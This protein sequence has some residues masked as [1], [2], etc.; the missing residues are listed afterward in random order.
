MIPLKILKMKYKKEKKIGLLTW[1]SQLNI[2]IYSYV[3]LTSRPCTWISCG[4]RF[5]SSL[6]ANP[7]LSHCTIF[8]IINKNNSGPYINRPNKYLYTRKLQLSITYN[9]DICYRETCKRIGSEGVITKAIL[10]VC[11]LTILL[12][13]YDML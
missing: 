11:W 9:N 5:F 1:R 10:Q 12:C 7:L 6:I 4:T 8:Y 3:K 13:D 2:L